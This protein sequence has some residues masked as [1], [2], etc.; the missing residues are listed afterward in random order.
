MNCVLFVIRMSAIIMRQL[1]VS[2]DV[3]HRHLP[4]VPPFI[5]N[6]LDADFPFRVMGGR[7]QF[8]FAAS[9]APTVQFLFEK[10]IEYWQKFRFYKRG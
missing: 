10:T 7:K 6:R 5:G 2:C 1:A 8:K 4:F 3:D 9:S